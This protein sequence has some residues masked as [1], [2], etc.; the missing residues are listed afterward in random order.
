MYGEQI[1]GLHFCGVPLFLE[2][3]LKDSQIER[4][5]N[6]IS[7]NILIM[8]PPYQITPKILK[9]ITSISEKI[10]EINAKYLDKQNPQ[11]RKQNK[12]KTIHS[13]LQIEGFFSPTSPL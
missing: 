9:L 5:T 13:S 4:L 8:E 7:D 3:G 6:R 1:E 11:L 2:D 12:I 10:R